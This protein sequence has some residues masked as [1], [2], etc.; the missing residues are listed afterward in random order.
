MAGVV[1]L[2]AL[3]LLFW[4]CRRRRKADKFDGNF[5]PDRI[6]ASRASH[7]VGRDDLLEGAQVTPYSYSPE[8]ASSVAPTS[9]MRQQGGDVNHTLLDCCWTWGSRGCSCRLRAAQSAT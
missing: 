6:D 5:D 2:A 8:N 4:F 3:I 9:E 1:A 7:G